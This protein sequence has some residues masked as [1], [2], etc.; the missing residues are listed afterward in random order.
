MHRHS[1]E[2]EAEEEFHPEAGGRVF[3]L[4]K[5]WQALAAL[6]PQLGTSAT[7]YRSPHVLLCR[8]GRFPEAKVSGSCAFRSG[9]RQGDSLRLDQ[10]HE[11]FWYQEMRD[12]LPRPCLE[13]VNELG[14]GFL[15]LCYRTPAEAEEDLPLIAGLFDGESDAW[16]LLH[17]RRA[18]SLDCGCLHRRRK[19]NPLRLGPYL[20]KIFLEAR[21]RGKPMGMILPHDPATTWDEM[22]P[23]DISRASCWLSVD[24]GGCHLHLRPSHFYRADVISRGARAV[25]LFADQDGEV[26]FTLIEPEGG[27]MASVTALEKALPRQHRSPS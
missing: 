16:N 26:I 24:A 6:L 19:V 4:K 5:D 15:K 10:W 7:I 27:R 2:S 14:Q 3:H 13:I 17:L 21:S 18:N 22:L 25:M 23:G 1:S 12:G 20:E 8:T 9:G 11:A